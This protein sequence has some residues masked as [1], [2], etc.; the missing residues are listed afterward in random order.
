MPD[1]Y[2]RLR[3]KFSTR[4]RAWAFAAF[5]C[6]TSG[7]TT[8]KLSDI[9][10]KHKHG[11]MKL[12]GL[13]PLM[14]LG[15]ASGVGKSLLT[16]A[17]CRIAHRQGIMV[18]PFKSQ[19]M[20]LNSF[21]TLQGAEIGRAQALQAHACGIEPEARFNPILL[22]PLGN[23]LSQVIVMGKAIGEMTWREYKSRFREMKAHVIAA[24]ESLRGDFDWIIIEGAGSPAEINLRREDLAN[25]S[26]A[27]L[28][29]AACLLI[30][31]IDR[32]GAFAALAGTMLLLPH[33]DRKRIAGFILNR[34]RGDPSL[35]NSA[36]QTVGRKTGRPFYGI[37]PM[38]E[39][40]RLPEEDSAGLP[41]AQKI[42][43]NETAR[44]QEIEIAV[45]AWPNA[46]N[47]TDF[48]PILSA[49]AHGLKYIRHPQDFGDPDLVILP[50]SRNV[51][52]SLAWLR[53][54]G[55]DGLL[56]NWLQ[57]RHEG[58]IRHLLGIC[59]GMEI[60]GQKILDPFKLEGGTID[61]L[62][63][64]PLSS[65]LM[66]EKTLTRRQARTLDFLGIGIEEAEGYEIHHGQLRISGKMEAV[67]ED[68]CGSACG[69]GIRRG[70]RC[71]IWGTWLHGL[72]DR[73]GFRSAYL[74]KIALDNAKVWRPLP[75][76]DENSE[77]DRLADAVEKHLDWQG[78]RRL[79]GF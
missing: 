78:V 57:K 26:I 30:A 19:N 69:W 25:M 59:G 42:A 74:Q 66:P 32:G 38:L 72:F 6:H 52:A 7:I 58:R 10:L 16:A 4:V 37:V 13:K 22:K 53:S 51:G 8:K 34:F 31:D 48:E 50:G 15:T 5:S 65:T 39:N 45:M 62:G 21:V 23:Q 71:I 55:L 1:L 28:T 70:S 41:L 73:P 11:A 27:R 61:G 17:L 60:L 2:A 12:S 63:L 49:T 68:S 64:L 35:L 47:M 18:A 40:L 14:L 54:S 77:L 3:R 36:L 79:A 56:L 29:D 75:E 46:S 67:L 43:R 33:Q 20:S 24:W 9:A 44:E 76:T